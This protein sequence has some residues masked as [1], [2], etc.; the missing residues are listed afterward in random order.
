MKLLAGI[1]KIFLSRNMFQSGMCRYKDFP[2][3]EEGRI[4]G[5]NDHFIW[6]VQTWV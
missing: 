2:M 3:S 5:M 4:P 1:G 6:T